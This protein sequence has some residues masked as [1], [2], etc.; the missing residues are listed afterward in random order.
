MSAPTFGQPLCSRC[1]GKG[2]ECGRCQGSGF[3]PLTQTEPD[4]AGAEA[5]KEAGIEKVTVNRDPAW[6]ALAFDAILLVAQR[7]PTLTTDDIH[8]ELG[9]QRVPEPREPRVYAAPMR[10]AQKAGV[11]EPTSEHRLS[12]R[13]QAHRNPKRV[14][15]SRVY[16]R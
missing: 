16:G 13:R 4:P 7:Q 8:Y 15:R 1:K 3:E 10:R 2:G 6:A 5:A 12:T 14:W 11:I 9:R